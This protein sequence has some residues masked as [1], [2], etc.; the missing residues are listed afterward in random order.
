MNSK[1]IILKSTPLFMCAALLLSGCGG[2]GS[3]SSTSTSSSGTTSSISGVAASGA[4]L[5]NANVTV[6]CSDGS[7]Q[8]GTT[9]D[10]GEFTI[11]LGASCAAPYVL[12]AK[13]ESGDGV[14]SL[15]SVFPDAISGAARANITPLTHAISATLASD[16]N[17]LSLARNIATE[18]NNITPAA[19]TSRNQAI[20]SSLSGMLTNA[21]IQ[22]TPNLITT[23][24]SANRTGLDKILDNLSVE[25][26]PS[27]VNI[28]NLSGNKVDDMG[29]LSGASVAPDLA[30]NSISINKSTNFNASIG[31]LPNAIQSADLADAAT[32]ALNACFQLPAASRIN[33]AGDLQGACATLASNHLA[34]DYKHDGKNIA[35]EWN[36][37]MRNTAYDKA[38]FQK[39]EIIRYF[40]DSPADTRALFRMGIIRANGAGEWYVSVVEKSN[41]TGGAL[42]LRGNQREFRVGVNA[43]VSREEQV[44]EKSVRT[45]G[46]VRD[47]A[48]GVHYHSGLNIQFTGNAANPVRY[49]KVTGPGLPTAGLILRPVS[50]CSYWA[51]APSI[52][53][54][55]TTC[56]S[57]YRMQY[58]KAG[59]SEKDSPYFVNG[60]NSSDLFF[61]RTRVSDSAIKDIKV[62]SAYRFQIFKVGNGTTTPDYDYIERLRGRP[63][64]LGTN[65]DIEGKLAEVDKL[66][67]NAGLAASTKALINPDLST[68]FTGGSSIK[69]DWANSPGAAPA[70]SF[71]AQ[72]R[73]QGGLSGTL[74]QDDQDVS[75]TATTVTLTNPPIG[76]APG[77][78]GGTGIDKSN[79]DNFMLIQLRA[80]DKATDLQFFNNWRY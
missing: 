16:G 33:T 7:T 56:T 35:Q 55:P 39:P 74:Y 62:F 43:Y 2:G 80:R 59:A 41:N 9:N 17:P 11:T 29:H 58:R 44:L 46:I 27:G 68:R 69:I 61:A 47:R 21:N 1:K 32:A 26:N 60:F 12:V 49:V 40:S 6:T 76:N 24:F 78:W 4:P 38:V 15:V 71:Q 50:G 63:I 65:S 20:V 67:F 52:T 18:K 14:Q 5:A 75:P 53:T 22:G 66:V 37:M 25:V 42:K 72:F 57:L 45:D 36:A 10:K 77:G 73:A 30:S 31:T 28:T 64:T 19:V 48:A 51:I 79:Q 13:S 70:N 3:S 8:N 23:E 54:T 34:S